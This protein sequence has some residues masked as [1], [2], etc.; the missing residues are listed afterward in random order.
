MATSASQA[1]AVPAGMI[2]CL[3]VTPESTLLDTTARMV[4]L[5]L[6]DGQAGIAPGHAPLIGRLGSGAVRISGEAAGEGGAR[7]V[8]VDGGFVEVNHDV[9]TVI[10]Q[11]ALPA[12][13]IDVGQA[14]AELEA[15]RSSRAAGDEAINE[16][17]HKQASSRAL[18]RAA[19]QARR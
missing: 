10:T 3:V 17:A 6:F 9:V 7:R 4:S 2:R 13:T 14:R 11:R 15:I 12:E 19:E 1:A 16:K 18:V 5:P 8:F